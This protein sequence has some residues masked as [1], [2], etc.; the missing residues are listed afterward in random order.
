M[1]GAKQQNQPCPARSTF[2]LGPCGEETCG[3]PR[4]PC[5]PTSSAA[6]LPKNELR[7]SPGEGEA[8]QAEDSRWSWQFRDV[9]SPPPPRQPASF[10]DGV[11]RWHLPRDPSPAGQKWGNLLTVVIN[12]PSTPRKGHSCRK[13][14]EN[15]TW[16]GG[17]R[18]KTFPCHL[19]EE[20]ERGGRERIISVR[21]FVQAVKVLRKVREREAMKLYAS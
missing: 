13:G 2:A 12:C 3:H 20:Q 16:A 8:A 14:Q 9:P 4:V 21:M 5:S 17:V 18:E 19:R 1:G 7:L 10:P 6:G 11:P 15:K